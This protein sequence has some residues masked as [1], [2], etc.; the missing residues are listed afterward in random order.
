MAGGGAAA[1]A[2]MAAKQRR[3]QEAVDAFRLGDATAA[4]RARRF[5]DLGVIPNDETRE[6]I[7]EGVLLPGA[8]EGTYYLSEAGY[9]Y[10]REDRKGMRA[11]AIV[12]VILVVI[13]ML[14]FGLAVGRSP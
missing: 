14:V 11:V 7:I 3:I 4:N 12:A 8:T 1:A 9:I 2:I 5:E 13:G 10:R 6:L